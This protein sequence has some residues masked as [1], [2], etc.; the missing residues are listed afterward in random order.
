[1]EQNYDIHDKE[2]LAI[3]EAFKRWRH[4]LEGM[5]A[6]VEVITLKSLT[7]RQA[8]WSEY[9]LQFNLKIYFR[10]GKLGTKPDALTQRWNVYP[11]EDQCSKK[12]TDPVINF[13]QTYLHKYWVFFSNLSC[14]GKPSRRPFQ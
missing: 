7:N 11:K 5:P 2:L 12:M 9:L 8:C 14:I 10:P 4:Y 13:I 3:F 1:V 6:P